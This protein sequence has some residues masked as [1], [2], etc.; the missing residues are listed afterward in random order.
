[1]E[2]FANLESGDGNSFTGFVLGGQ[3]FQ[4]DVQGSGVGQKTDGTVKTVYDTDTMGFEF[5]GVEFFN[6]YV[7]EKRF[8]LWVVTEKAVKRRKRLLKMPIHHILYFD[9]EIN[10]TVF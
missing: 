5:G 2:L 10:N 7:G 9:N 8:S 6:F 4:L 1:M 3:M